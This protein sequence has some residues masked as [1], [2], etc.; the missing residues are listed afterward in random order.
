MLIQTKD[1]KIQFQ[2][3]NRQQIKYFRALKNDKKLSRD[4]FVAVHEVAYMLNEFVW[5]IDTFPNLIM[6]C[7]M[8]KILDLVSLCNEPIVLSYDTTFCLGDFYVSALIVKLNTFDE[9]PIVPIGFVVHERKFES[10]H[11][12][13]FNHLLYKMSH[14]R[15]Y[16]IVTDG[17]QGVVSAIVNVMSDWTLASCYNHIL[18]DVEF[19]LKKNK[20]SNNDI[21]IYK[22]QVRELL[23][24]NT[25]LELAMK[26]QTV[27]ESWSIAFRAY[28]DARISKR[29]ELGYN[30][31]LKEVGIEADLI[32]TNASESLNALLKRYT[33]MRCFDFSFT[34]L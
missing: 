15:R 10:V 34:L 16:V 3:R 2:P 31:Y 30:G 11:R 28:Y 27:R 5:S 24:C 29:V 4:S 32:T 17:E 14:N 18:M 13:F 19:W 33:V 12:R 23:N 20:A 1:E 26:G 6:C 21:Q 7:G 9:K 25:S 22:S 8:Q